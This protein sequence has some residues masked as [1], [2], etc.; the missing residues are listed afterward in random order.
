MFTDIDLV[1]GVHG[2]HGVFSL[3]PGVPRSSETYHPLQTL[4]DILTLQ[5]AFGQQDLSGK[6]LAWV[7]DGNNVLHSLM[8]GC[9]HVGMNVRVATPDGYEPFP[10]VVSTAE[11]VAD[12]RHASHPRAI[13][14]G[15]RCCCCGC[16]CLFVFVIL[17]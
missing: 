13:T 3:L 9:P 1:C 14:G 16:C 5:E 17:V 11:D 10:D 7:G 8:L 2:V 15:G 12:V 6:T 4:A